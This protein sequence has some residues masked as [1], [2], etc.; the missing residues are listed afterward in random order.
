MIN[1]GK[2]T[3][4]GSPLPTELPRRKRGRPRKQPQEP[5]EP[6]PPKKP[7]GRPKGSKKLNAGA[8][9]MASVHTVAEK[10]PRGRPRKWLILQKE[11]YKKAGPEGRISPSPAPEGPTTEG[12]SSGQGCPKT[13][14]VI[15][16]K[17]PLTTSPAV[18]Q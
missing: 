12:T 18:V 4:Q 10:K 3:G 7:R 6:L 13:K 9:Q 16:S 8:G 11:E 2:P 14:R 5:V 17:I 15:E 1:A